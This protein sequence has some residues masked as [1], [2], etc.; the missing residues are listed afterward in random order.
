MKVTED[1]VLQLLADYTRWKYEDE[2][3]HSIDKC[4]YDLEFTDE[5][6]VYKQVLTWFM[7][8]RINPATGKTVLEEFIEQFIKDN[9]ALSN[10]VRGLGHLIADT[11]VI[12]SREGN[13]I[14]LESVSS[15][16]RFN[17][18]AVPEHAEIYIAGRRVKGRLYRWGEVY[19]FAGITKIEKSDEEI[20]QETGIITPGIMMK[21]YENRFLKQAESVL[22]N[23]RSSLSSLLNKLDWTWINGICY[24]LKVSKRGNKREK[25]KRIVAVLDSPNLRDIVYGLPKDARKALLFVMREGGMV[26]YSDLVKQFHDDTGMWWEEDPPCSEVGI[27]RRYGLLVIG[28]IPKHGRFYKVA[29]I[30]KEIIQRLNSLGIP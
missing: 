30:P 24:S 4:P 19:R 1:N 14:V 29:I 17:V 3:L 27:L 5:E 10:K 25:V 20:F 12:L 22:V 9:D 6:F 7:L 16:K 13:I 2:V 28:R 15:S 21:W 11:F 8:E 23:S 18:W 26:R